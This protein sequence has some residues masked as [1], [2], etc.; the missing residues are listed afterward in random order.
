MASSNERIT[1]RRLLIFLAFMLVLSYA[2]PTLFGLK[3]PRLT[4]KDAMTPL[5]LKE[6]EAKELRDEIT[7]L[8]DRLAVLTARNQLSEKAQNLAMAKTREAEEAFA[9]AET[10]ALAANEAFDVADLKE[11]EAKQAL[12]YARMTEVQARDALR[13]ANEK[14]KVA[15][16]QR[17]AEYRK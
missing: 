8:E 2:M 13:E 7:K 14:E 11:K 15:Q 6:L 16:R 10:D 3:P 17:P 9:A 5:Q 4:P 1:N 12:R